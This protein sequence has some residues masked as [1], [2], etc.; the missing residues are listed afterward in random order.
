MFPKSGKVLCA[1]LL[2]LCLLPLVSFNAHA[3]IITTHEAVAMESGQSLTQVDAWL[4][5]DD[6]VAEL[7]AL[8]VDPDLARIR[9]EALSPA[10]LDELAN[11]IDELPAGAGVI[12]VLGIT[13]LVLIILEVIGVTN[14][15]NR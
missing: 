11:R 6:V 8:G 3:E 2:G 10:E 12:E 9:A 5:R 13:F 15:F 4:Q 7:A 14:I 1:A